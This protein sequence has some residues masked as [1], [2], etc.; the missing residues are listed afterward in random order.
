MN[1]KYT[2]MKPALDAAGNFEAEDDIDVQV[3]YSNSTNWFEFQITK[4]DETKTHRIILADFMFSVNTYSNNEI[5]ILSKKLAAVLND[6]KDMAS[7]E[8]V[9]NLLP[10]QDVKEYVD[11]KEFLNFFTVL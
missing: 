1:T 7:A 10:K 9:I 8:V 5:F 3:S 11:I 4:L 2:L 6:I